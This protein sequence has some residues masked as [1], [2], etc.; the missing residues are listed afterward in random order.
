MS[1]PTSGGGSWGGTPALLSRGEGAERGAPP[2]ASSS[3]SAP[4]RTHITHSRHTLTVTL[5]ACS[6][7]RIIEHRT[8]QEEGDFAPGIH[9]WSR[10]RKGKSRAR[11]H[12]PAT[13]LVPSLWLTT[14]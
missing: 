12:E 2:L 10:A 7:P 8:A 14:E 5:M 9:L 4:H 3:T 6:A 11:K 1:R 13:P